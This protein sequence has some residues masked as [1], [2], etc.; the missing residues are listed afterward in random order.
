[1]TDIGNCELLNVSPAPS[2][3][4]GVLAAVPSVGFV[5]SLRRSFVVVAAARDS[6]R[7]DQGK[8]AQDQIVQVMSPV[9]ASTALQRIVARK[10]ATDSAW[11][12]NNRALTRWVER[13]II[14]TY[15]IDKV[16]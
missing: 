3:I 10:H 8:H 9:L 2:S 11:V 14:P 6:E 12:Y 1:V 7:R 5:G 13:D 4:A 16:D 15:R